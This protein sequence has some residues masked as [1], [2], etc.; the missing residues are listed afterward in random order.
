MIEVGN[1]YSGGPIPPIPVS[2]DANML[3]NQ[4][5]LPSNELSARFKT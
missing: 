2:I 4:Q 5:L 1:R 3:M